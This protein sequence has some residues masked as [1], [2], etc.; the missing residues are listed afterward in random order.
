MIEPN[1]I[2]A[3]DR[4]SIHQFAAREPEFFENVLLMW[5]PASAEDY[6]KMLAA[7]VDR[8]ELCSTFEEF[9]RVCSE[10]CEALVA[11][12]HQV[13]KVTFAVDALIAWCEATERPLDEVARQMFALLTRAKGG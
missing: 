3:A 13:E 8:A 1:C 10:R 2:R 6:S 7:A 12:G 5:W 4:E 9:E 11:A